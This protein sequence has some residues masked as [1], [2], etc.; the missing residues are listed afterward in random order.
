MNIRPETPADFPALYDFIREAFKTAP[1]S[2]G[3]EQDFVCL[4]YTSD[5]ADDSVYV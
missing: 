5:A 4:L 2:D 3:T 1:V